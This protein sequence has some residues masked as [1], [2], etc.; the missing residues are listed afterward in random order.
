M[1]VQQAEQIFIFITLQYAMFWYMF[2]NNVNYWLYK[3][4]S[5]LLCTYDHDEIVIGCYNFAYK[6]SITF[7]SHYHDIRYWKVQRKFVQWIQSTIIMK[8]KINRPISDIWTTK[9]KHFETRFKQFDYD[10]I[11]VHLRFLY[12]W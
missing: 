12:K 4:I 8:I 3:M 11:K 1:I 2:I 9:L 5:S 7:V 10:L 6:G